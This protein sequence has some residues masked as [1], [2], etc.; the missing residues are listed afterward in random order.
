MVQ[1]AATNTVIMSPTIRSIISK[2]YNIPGIYNI[3]AKVCACVRACV[4]VRVCVCA[5]VRVCECA[6]VLR[7]F[8]PNSPNWSCPSLEL[9]SPL[10]VTHLPPVC[11][12]LLP[13]TSTPDRKD[14]WL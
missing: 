5:C 8:P 10:Q 3:H 6:C 11:D 14:Y 13:L 4:C 12:L 1:D 9:A 7:Y 2:I